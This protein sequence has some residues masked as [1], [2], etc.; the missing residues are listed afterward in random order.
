MD[1]KGGVAGA[2]PE[3]TLL[4]LPPLK[5]ATPGNLQD[6][7]L[8]I[9][10][11]IC[12]FPGLALPFAPRKRQGGGVARD[13]DQLYK[14]FTTTPSLKS[15]TSDTLEILLKRYNHESC[16]LPRVALPRVSVNGRGAGGPAWG[17]A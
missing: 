13:L 5:S 1:G 14:H 16:K 8:Y 4:Q 2:L 17:L 10:K 11:R 15:A 3:N 7:R 9:F 12:K 6:S